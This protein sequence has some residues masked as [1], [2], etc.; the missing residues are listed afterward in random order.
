MNRSTEHWNKTMTPTSHFHRKIHIAF[1][2][3]LAWCRWPGEHTILV[4]HFTSFT[5]SDVTSSCWTMA[6]PVIPS[7]IITISNLCTVHL[8]VQA[9]IQWPSYVL[10]LLFLDLLPLITL[11]RASNVQTTLHLMSTQWIPSGL[12]CLVLGKTELYCWILFTLQPC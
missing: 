3:S 12:K 9:F 6:F 10:F 2:S 8:L 11:C 7:W 1:H 5:L 4:G